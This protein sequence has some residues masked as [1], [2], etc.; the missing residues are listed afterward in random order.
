[1]KHEILTNPFNLTASS[2]VPVADVR[3]TKTGFE[4]LACPALIVQSS[5]DGV[6]ICGVV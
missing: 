5:L 1:M 3:R 4:L 2:D 6:S